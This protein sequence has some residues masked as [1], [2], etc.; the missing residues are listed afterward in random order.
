MAYYAHIRNGVIEGV[1]TCFAVAIDMKDVEI[2]EDLY[3]K[4]LKDKD[5]LIIQDDEVVE[6]PNYEALKEEQRK[7]YFEAKFFKTHLGFVR[8]E[9]T[10]K[11]GAK[12][13]FLTD[14]LTTL[15]VGLPLF[16][17]A[18]PDYTKE[19][20]EADILA[21]QQIEYVDE[22]FIAECKNQF[23]IDFYGFNPMEVVANGGNE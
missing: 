7:A 12:K 17:Y 13:D 20:T 5:Y 8:R 19:V 16:V 2:S 4:Y 1:G 18:Q 11:N 10:M 14:M 6:N 3:N 9:V 15:Q 21:T 23:A 22:Q